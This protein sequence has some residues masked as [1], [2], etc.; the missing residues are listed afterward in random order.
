MEI[1]PTQKE[2]RNNILRPI[3]EEVIGTET[4]RNMIMGELEDKKKGV[5]I[6]D[7]YESG[8]GEGCYYPD[9]V[10]ATAD[11]VYQIVQQ[12]ELKE[13]LSMPKMKYALVQNYFSALS[14]LAYAYMENRL[15]RLYKTK[16]E[17]DKIL[18][19]SLYDLSDELS[20]FIKKEQIDGISKIELELVKEVK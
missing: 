7:R 1:K 13:V 10:T 9:K 8:Y 19:D 18:D 12:L 6:L 3:T 5:K 15:D 4:F 17:G 16:I 14:D 20:R 2:D 11:Y